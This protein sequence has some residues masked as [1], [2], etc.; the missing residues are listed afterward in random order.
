MKLHQ[1]CGMNERAFYCLSIL[2]SL[3]PPQIPLDS[4]HIIPLLLRTC[5]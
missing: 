3:P 2:I 5:I 4:R 1:N